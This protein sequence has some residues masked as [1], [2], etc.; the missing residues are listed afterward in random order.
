MA[1]GG[2]SGAL[3]AACSCVQKLDGKEGQACISPTVKTFLKVCMAASGLYVFIVP[4]FH[5][6]ELHVANAKN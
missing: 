3:T 2:K 6:G 1:Q 4:C 5:E